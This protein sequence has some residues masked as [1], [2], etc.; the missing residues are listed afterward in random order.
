MVT[1]V[2]KLPIC[3]LQALYYLL[4][5]LCFM[6]LSPLLTHAKHARAHTHRKGGRAEK[7]RERERESRGGQTDRET[8]TVL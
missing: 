6:G 1:A 4:K 3:T 5:M 7:E 2:S 8:P